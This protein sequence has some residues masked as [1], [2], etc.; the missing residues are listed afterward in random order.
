MGVNTEDSS[1]LSPN[2]LVRGTFGGAGDEGGGGGALNS[3]PS[4]RPGGA[5]V[6]G[7][8]EL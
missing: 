1:I 5:A 7:G 4:G 6:A 8:S 2:G 3:E